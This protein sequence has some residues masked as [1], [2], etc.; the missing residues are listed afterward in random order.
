MA[1]F[2]KP[3]GPCECVSQSLCKLHFSQLPLQWWYQADLWTVFPQMT[4]CQAN[5]INVQAKLKLPSGC[6]WRQH[7]A[8]YWLSRAI[9]III[10]IMHL[11]MRF[12]MD[13]GIKSGNNPSKVHSQ[14]FLKGLLAISSLVLV[15]CF[16][17]YVGRWWL[18]Q[19]Y[20]Q[21]TPK[22]RAEC[23]QCLSLTPLQ[24]PNLL[25]L[26]NESGGGA[27]CWLCL[28]LPK[29]IFSTALWVTSICLFLNGPP[30]PEM[31]W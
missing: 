15:T 16:Y 6:P 5:G 8:W 30:G 9:I 17:L 26:R 11:D 2:R 3:V 24:S 28:S 1:S 7:G 22:I 23:G 13:T 21:Y 14:A 12:I 19:T 10:I 31:P 20:C 29:P 25:L 18:E 4:Q 27:F